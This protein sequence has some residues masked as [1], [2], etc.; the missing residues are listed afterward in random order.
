MN[1][2][3]SETGGK[4]ILGVVLTALLA[5]AKRYGPVV[6]EKTKEAMPRHH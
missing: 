4:V 6:F 1:P 3:I 5:L 2:K